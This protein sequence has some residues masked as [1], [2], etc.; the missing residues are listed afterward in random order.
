MVDSYLESNHYHAALWGAPKQET[1]GVNVVSLSPAMLDALEP[2]KVNGNGK[3]DGT[4][5][6]MARVVQETLGV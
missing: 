1:A 2:M 6:D 5:V 3:P 4:G